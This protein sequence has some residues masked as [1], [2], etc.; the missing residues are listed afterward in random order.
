MALVP[1]LRFLWELSR[2]EKIQRSPFTPWQ[3]ADTSKS[4]C[5]SHNKKSNRL[6]VRTYPVQFGEGLRKIVKSWR[7]QPRLRQKREVNLELSDREL[8]A[9][10]PLGDLWQDADLVSVYK[11]LRDSKKTAVPNSWQ[12]VFDELD[13]ELKVAWSILTYKPKLIIQN[14]LED[15]FMFLTCFDAKRV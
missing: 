5:H 14:A 2:R 7:P 4:V 1:D 10:V 11:Y 3:P 12:T 13:V 6:L 8:F 15:G 9:R